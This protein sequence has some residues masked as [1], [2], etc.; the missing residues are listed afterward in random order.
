[1]ED[2]LIADPN[3]LEARYQVGIPYVLRGLIIHLMNDL[4]DS[5]D[6]I[7]ELVTINQQLANLLNSY[8]DAGLYFERYLTQ[9]S[10]TQFSGIVKRI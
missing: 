10:T 4:L 5:T 6:F 8:K 1:M 3:D 7:N 9:L 2:Y